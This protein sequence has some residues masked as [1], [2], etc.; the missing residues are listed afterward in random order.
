MCQRGASLGAHVES[1]FVEPAWAF[2]DLTTWGLGSSVH[3]GED[4]GVFTAPWA[5]QPD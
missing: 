5:E 1:V 2:L 3:P 4:P